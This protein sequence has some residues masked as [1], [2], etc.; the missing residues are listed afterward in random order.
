[1]LSR[2]EEEE[3]YRHKEYKRM[4]AKSSVSRRA[5][6]QVS[7]FWPRTLE[8]QGKDGFKNLSVETGDLKGNHCNKHKDNSKNCVQLKTT[9]IS[10]GPHNFLCGHSGLGLPG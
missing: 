9:I 3:K 1:M 5:M 6:E 8:L 7:K 2:L 10:E 4:S